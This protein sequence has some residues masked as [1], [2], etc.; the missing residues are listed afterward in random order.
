MCPLGRTQKTVSQSRNHKEVE[1]YSEAL[2]FN[3]LKQ[4][5]YFQT[6]RYLDAEDIK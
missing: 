4:Q 1:V 2:V 5:N 6:K 3:K